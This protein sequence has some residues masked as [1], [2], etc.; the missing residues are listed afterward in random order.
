MN[1][2]KCFANRPTAC[3]GDI[4]WAA[5][6]VDG[7]GCISLSKTRQPGRKHPTYRPRFD[8]GQNNREVLVEV[9]EILGETA[10][11]YVNKRRPGQN[12]QTY[13]LVYDGVHAL[14]AVA[15]LRS[16]LRR[17]HVEADELLSYPKRC[18]MGVHPGPKGYPPEVW[19]ER[20]RI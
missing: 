7:E 18:W 5:G 12:R 6:F 3:S 4:A 13:S 20:E 17:K 10:G 1:P 15:K 2:H 11:L 16:E 19:I 9:Q 14:R 8:L